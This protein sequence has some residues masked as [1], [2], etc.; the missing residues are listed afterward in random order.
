MD[1]HSCAFQHLT[2]TKDFFELW[3]HQN[4]LAFVV[5]LLLHEPVL[6]LDPVLP[7]LMALLLLVVE[8]QVLMVERVWQESRTSLPVPMGLPTP[9]Q[10]LGRWALSN[11]SSG[12]TS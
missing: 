12:K 9:K 1:R 3:K 2:P 10:G 8:A 6:L 11:T 4:H 7:A 5:G